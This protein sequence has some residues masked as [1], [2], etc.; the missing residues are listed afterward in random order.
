MYRSASVLLFAS[1]LFLADVSWA[2]AQ[3][4]T[5]ETREVVSFTEVALSMPG[6]LHLRQGT[7]RS[8]DVKAPADV[9]KH[10]ETTVE[11]GTLKIRDER[12]PAGFLESLF[13]GGGAETEEEI[14]A[15]VTVPTVEGVSL[16]GAGTVVGETPIEASS[17]DLRSAGSGDMQLAIRVQELEVESAGA[18]TFDLKGTADEVAVAGA[19]AGTV[20]AIDLTT[21][22]AEVEVAGAGDVR[23]HVTDRLSVDIIGAGDIEHRG[24]PDIETNIIG[25]GEVRSVE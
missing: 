19:G 11:N 14:E 12:A 9:L 6:T 8:V 1:I 4:R 3:D 23:L 21:K 20:E 18:S 15:Y 5:Q 22:T 10:V 13:G 17:L 24:S 25:S 16:A 2:H 7:P